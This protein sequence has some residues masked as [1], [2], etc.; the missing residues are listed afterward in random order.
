MNFK[1]Y[2]DCSINSNLKFL[3][4]TYK[5]SVYYTFILFELEIKHYLF[6]V[7]IN[8]PLYDTR[9]YSKYP[10]FNNIELLSQ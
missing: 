5:V 8:T 4:S 10:S 7:H 6:T 9:Y 2:F 1:T 3:P